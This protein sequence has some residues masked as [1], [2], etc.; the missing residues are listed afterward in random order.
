MVWLWVTKSCKIHHQ[1]NISTERE[2]STI[3][4][5]IKQVL[6]L[7]FHPMLT[8]V[9]QIHICYFLLLLPHFIFPE[10]IDTRAIPQAPPPPPPQKKKVN[11][12]VTFLVLFSRKREIA[13]LSKNLW[14]YLS[15]LLPQQMWADK[16][17]KLTKPTRQKTRRTLRFRFYHLFNLKLLSAQGAH[18][19]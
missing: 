2:D 3:S 9:W 16:Y 19:K 12:V 18:Y 14:K 13:S 15:A 10:K 11:L 6:K 7:Y 17:N 8:V 4:K 1:E 5:H